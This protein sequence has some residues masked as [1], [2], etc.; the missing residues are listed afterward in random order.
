VQ[1]KVPLAALFVAVAFYMSSLAAGP[2][3]AASDANIVDCR[4][5]EAHTSAA[6]PVIVVVFHQRDRQ[7]QGRLAAL[8]KQ[9]SGAAAAIQ[10]GDTQWITVTVFRMKSCFGRGLLL[11][12]MG[13]PP[14]KNGAAFRLRF[15]ASN[16]KN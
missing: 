5:L 13:A 12:S 16:A 8:L 9:D 4:V 10:A 6:P 2:Q 11:L 7:D 3:T 1:R 15:S 14:L